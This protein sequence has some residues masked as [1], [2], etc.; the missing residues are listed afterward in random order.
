MDLMLKKIH[1]MDRSLFR[2]IVNSL[3]YY[4]SSFILWS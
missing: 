2:N 4:L 3:I 1:I